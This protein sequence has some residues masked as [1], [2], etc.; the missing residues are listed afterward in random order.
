MAVRDIVRYLESEAVLRKKSRP[1]RRV[2]R[3]VARLVQDLK[4][5]LNAHAN[6]IGLAAPRS[7]FTAG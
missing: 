5:T 2:A 3:Q 7:T 1:V 6:G 4:D